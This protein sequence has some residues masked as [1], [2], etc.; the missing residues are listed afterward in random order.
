MALAL[1]LALMLAAAVPVFAAQQYS[2][3]CPRC[4]RQSYDAG[5]LT[6]TGY[7]YYDGYNHSV[8][9]YVPQICGNCA[10]GFNSYGSYE[11]AHAGNPCVKC[12]YP[13]YDR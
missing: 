11:E 13:N 2:N 4:Y 5:S 7:T 10:Y 1:V 3:V 8:N 6:I 12:N 9:Y